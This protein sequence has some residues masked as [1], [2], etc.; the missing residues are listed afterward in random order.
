MKKKMKNKIPDL[1]GDILLSKRNEKNCASKSWGDILWPQNLAYL[2]LNVQDLG[3]DIL[4]K[5][6]MKKGHGKRPKLD[7]N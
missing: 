1:W 3:G 2:H 4:K 5:G 7:A 6:K